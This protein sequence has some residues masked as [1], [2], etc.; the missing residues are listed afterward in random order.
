[1]QRE[2]GNSPWG[3]SMGRAELGPVG[4]STG[5]PPPARA[6]APFPF[7]GLTRLF[8]GLLTLA[9]L[10]RLGWESG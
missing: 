2:E 5:L 8:L 1:M 3:P 10:I 4:V 7:L 9:A 6:A